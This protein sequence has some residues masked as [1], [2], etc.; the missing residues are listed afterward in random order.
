MTSECIPHQG[1]ID[2]AIV[3]RIATDDEL[4]CQPFFWSAAGM[5]LFG[6]SRLD[7]TALKP[8]LVDAASQ[9]PIIVAAFL[10][11]VRGACPGLPW[12]G[13]GAAW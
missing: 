9:Q 7:R 13:C 5:K 10:E 4:T 8:L 2:E 11:Q 12:L 6:G 3:Q 1:G